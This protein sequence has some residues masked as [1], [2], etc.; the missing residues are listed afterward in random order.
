MSI[1]IFEKFVTFDPLSRMKVPNWLHYFEQ[2]YSEYNLGD[3]WTAKNIL[4]FLKGNTCVDYINKMMFV[5]RI[6]KS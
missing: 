2:K 6:G 5:K 1:K 4:S 3:E